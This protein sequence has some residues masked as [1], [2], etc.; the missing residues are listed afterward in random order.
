M[1]DKTTINSKLSREELDAAAEAEKQRQ[2]KL[3][4]EGDGHFVILEMDQQSGSQTLISAPNLSIPITDAEGNQATDPET[5]EP[6]YQWQALPFAHKVQAEEWVNERGERGFSYLILE[7]VAGLQGDH[8]KAE[9]EALA[10]SD[11]EAM[12]EAI[13]QDQKDRQD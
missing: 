12:Q 7:A 1:T 11:A 9:L 5:G 6:L 10:E 4:H 2:K 13:A 3:G 8:T